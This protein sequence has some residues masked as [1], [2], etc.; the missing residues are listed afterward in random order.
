MVVRMI[1]SAA[2][3]IV[4][5]LVCAAVALA[6]CGVDRRAGA[7]R[8]PVAT[9]S[10]GSLVSCPVAIRG[11]GLIAFTAKGRLELVDLASCRE[12]E[13]AT[14]VAEGVRFSPDGRW[15]AYSRLVGGEPAGPVVITARGGAGSSPLG[16]G[17]V[18]WSWALRRDV[19]YGVNG[20]GQLV[21]AAPRGRRRIVAGRVGGVALSPDGRLLASDLSR[22]EPPQ[23]ELDTIS[24]ASG[25]RVVVLRRAGELATLAGWSP[26]G[27]WLLYWAASQCS[28]SLAADGWPLEAVP[29]A[30]GGRSVKAVAH[31]LLFPD[32]LTWCGKRLIAAA[33]PSRE[34]QLDS[35]LVATWPPSW[36][37][38]TIESASKLSWVS[39]ACA[40]SGTMLAAAAGPNTEN[41]E[42]GVE[43]RSI[44]LLRPDGTV[45]Q[46][47]TSPP[48][49]DLSDEAPRFSRDGRWILFVRSQVIPAGQSAISRDTLELAPAT[50]TA[51]A[52]PIIGF[53][54]DDFSSGWRPEHPTNRR[55]PGTGRIELRCGG[56]H[57][58]HRRSLSAAR[59]GR[60]RGP[61]PGTLR[62]A[63]RHP[64]LPRTPDHAVPVSR[65]RRPTRGTRRSVRNRRRQLT[66]R[67]DPRSHT[68]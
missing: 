63:D 58:A 34:T 8:V 40:P 68:R 3:V 67:V 45:V 33:G 17:I 5:A 6:G 44:W 36:R 54:S 22:C 30:A 24:L 10:D 23:T 48:T 21:A 59:A 29:A 19:L 37:Q 60:R 43:H 7:R 25:A 1:R 12:I 56:A 53:T 2:T 42:F 46:Q 27:R 14:G 49:L 16:P 38:R 55:S 51:T 35:T 61:R 57:D 11:L 66:L 26:D 62:A 20:R 65:Q 4:V 41:A 18:A 52:V 47:L 50:G 39:P 32:F 15:L 31:M 64:P 13:L 28:A 9:G